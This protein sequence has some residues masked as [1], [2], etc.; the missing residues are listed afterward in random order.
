[1]ELNDDD[2][3]NELQI[4]SYDENTKTLHLEGGNTVDLGSLQQFMENGNAL[5]T[6]KVLQ[7]TQFTTKD[8]RTDIEGGKL[9]LRYGNGINSDGIEMGVD[10]QTGLPFISFI[11]SEGNTLGAIRMG[12]DGFKYYQN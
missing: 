4:L 3:T 1:V 8:G 7:A 5:C 10:D 9:S 6:D 11:D 12:P 2:P